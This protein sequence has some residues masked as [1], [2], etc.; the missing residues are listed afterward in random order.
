MTAPTAESLITRRL[1]TFSA[2]LRDAGFILGMK[3]S[4][5]AARILASPLARS[6]TTLRPAFRALFAGRHA[7]WERFDAIF[8]AA[9][10][11]R[12]VHQAVRTFGTPPARGPRSLRELAAGSHAKSRAAME[13]AAPSTEETEFTGEG[14]GMQGGASAAEGN[15]ARDLRR[16]ADPDPLA[17]AE[18]VARDLTAQLL[19]RHARR[20]RRARRH[21]RLDLRRTIRASLGHGGT[22][23]TLA[24]RR[25]RPLPL[26]IAMLIDVSGS[27]APHT[28]LFLRLA[29]GFIRCAA[30]AEIYL[31]HT[32]LVAVAEAMRD[33]D[34]MRALDRLT[35]LSKGVGGGTRLGECLAQF[36]QFH[37]PHAL[38][39]RAVCF[40]ISDGY[41]TGDPARL[42]REMK[43]L[44]RRC[45]RLV[46]LNP[47]A[48]SPGYEPAAQGMQAALPHIR[49]FAAA[50]TLETL[51][52]LA[53]PLGRL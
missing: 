36:N 10:L 44:R 46:W 17:G 28:P 32:R 30:R 53:E 31:I 47:A 16:I 39:G 27:M 49:L 15:A 8:D 33:R 13:E 51:S 34:R 23:F 14:T 48:L 42:G 26:R 40:I 38:A 18:A 29:L 24:W 37:A 2:T 52:A 21:G 3:E 7:E 20:R 5:D 11:G 45:R 6:P 41:E 1:A 43:A 25:P 12:R 35:L 22:P 9:F 4:E 50:G 19:A